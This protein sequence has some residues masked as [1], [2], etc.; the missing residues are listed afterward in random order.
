MGDKFCVQ[1]AKW[2]PEDCGH[3]FWVAKDP[4]HPLLE[5]PPSLHEGQDPAKNKSSRL[6]ITKAFHWPLFIFAIL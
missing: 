5:R 4:S 3:C 2:Q 6:K 1:Q